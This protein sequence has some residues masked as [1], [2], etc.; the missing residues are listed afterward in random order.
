MSYRNDITDS[1]NVAVGNACKIHWGRSV[2]V[3]GGVR[4]RWFVV[5][6]GDGGINWHDNQTGGLLAVFRLKSDSW[7]LERG[8]EVVGGGIVGE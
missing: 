5:L 3:D 8:G 1:L 2:L 6:D 4:G 7:V